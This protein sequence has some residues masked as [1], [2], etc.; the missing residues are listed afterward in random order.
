MKN[1]DTSDKQN[2]LLAAGLDLLSIQEVHE[3]VNKVDTLS[4]FS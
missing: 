1:S 3:D 2:H 4:K